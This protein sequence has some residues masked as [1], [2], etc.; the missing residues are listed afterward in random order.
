MQVTSDQLIFAIYLQP[1]A[2]VMKV[3]GLYNGHLKIKVAAAAVDNQANTALRT[4]IAQWLGVKL[5]QVDCL[6]GRQSR[7]K[8]IAVTLGQ[9]TSIEVPDELGSVMV[10]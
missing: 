5:R 9:P 2:K 4:M 10:V 7:Y 6:T 3:V 1:N 8:K